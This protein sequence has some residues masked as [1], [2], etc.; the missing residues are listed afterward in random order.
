M[1]FSDA[2]L[3]SSDAKYVQCV[4]TNNGVLGTN[5][6]CGHG[7]FVMNGG[8]AQPGCFT[9]TCAHSRAI[10]YFAE[11]L[12]PDHIFAS[13]RCENLI[14]NLFFELIAQ[15]CSYV[16]DRLG[17][18]SARKLGTYYVST[19]SIPPYASNAWKYLLRSK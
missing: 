5:F 18:H 9:P 11:S 8:L 6:N 14:K 4:Y 10:E 19:N 15:P 2:R 3:D 1:V 7:N 16:L 13:D 17:I 12:N